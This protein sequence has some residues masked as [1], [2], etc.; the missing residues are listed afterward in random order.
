MSV[1]NMEFINARIKELSAYFLEGLL[2]LKH[3]NGLPL[4]RLYGPAHTEKRGGTFLM[5][6]M[7][8][9]GRMYPFQDVEDRAN[10]AM[11]SL[12]SGC[13]CNPGIDELNHGISEEELRG[14]FVNRKDG[15]YHE[16][17]QIWEDGG[18]PY[19]FRSATRPQ[20]GYREIC[21]VAGKFLNKV[22]T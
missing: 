9:E 21:F 11:I 8:A 16:M 2:K 22:M 7:D 3:D 17:I 10:A 12:R 15:D 5:N 19:G 13:F 6:L 20:G 18:E 1:L 4:I 14:F